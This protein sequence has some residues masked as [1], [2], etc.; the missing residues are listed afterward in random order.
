VT[1]RCA[2]LVSWVTSEIPELQGSPVGCSFRLPLLNDSRSSLQTSRLVLPAHLVGNSSEPVLLFWLQK[3]KSL[4]AVLFQVY[5]LPSSC[6]LPAPCLVYLHPVAWDKGV[7]TH[8][9]FPLCNVMELQN[10]PAWKG[11]TRITEVRQ[12]SYS[13]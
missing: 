1:Q 13:Y 12:T 11:P 3:D 4:N 10:I 7:H 6:I 2:L 5:S 9:Y 8:W